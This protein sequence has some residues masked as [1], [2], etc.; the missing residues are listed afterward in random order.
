M[1][2]GFSSERWHIFV[3]N[4]MILRALTLFC[5]VFDRIYVLGLVG[6]VGSQRKIKCLE[7]LTESS[8]EIRSHGM[9]VILHNACFKSCSSNFLIL[10]DDCDYIVFP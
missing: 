1:A 2:L 8:M 5:L 3:A 9:L 10:L 6:I 4:Y 7:W